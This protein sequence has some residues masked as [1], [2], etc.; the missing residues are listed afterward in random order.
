MIEEARRVALMANRLHGGRSRLT[1]FLAHR[2]AA[3]END[4]IKRGNGDDL[5]SPENR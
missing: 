3:S 1:L 4:F 5:E 2:C